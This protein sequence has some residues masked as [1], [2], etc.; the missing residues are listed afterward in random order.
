M[1]TRARSWTT[2]TSGG[3]RCPRRPWR[4][5]RDAADVDDVVHA[6]DA[7]EGR[8][9]AARRADQAM[10]SLNVEIARRCSK[11]RHSRLEGKHRRPSRKSSPRRPGVA[12]Q[13]LLTVPAP[14]RLD[15]CVFR[16]FSCPSPDGSVRLTTAF[17]FACAAAPPPRSS[18]PETEQH[19]H[20][21]AGLLDE[22]A[23]REIGPEVDLHRQHRR[24]VGEGPP[25]R[26][27]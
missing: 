14:R 22:G 2:S 24:R 11:H 4:C 17:K 3:R 19:H 1:P 20:R 21:R 8:L 10:T 23:L 15:F 12:R 7:A 13:R 25:A 26:R 5:C 18:R 16:H 9:A 27:R 6:V